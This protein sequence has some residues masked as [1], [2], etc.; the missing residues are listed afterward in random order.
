MDTALALKC[1]PRKDFSAAT[2]DAVNFA[3]SVAYY[4]FVNGIYF[5]E[6]LLDNGTLMFV[7]GAGVF[8]ERNA[9]GTCVKNKSPV[10]VVS[11]L[12]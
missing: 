8:Y 2:L 6:N 1:G 4:D 11:I 10:E 12:G 5:Y 3:P 7:N 9:D